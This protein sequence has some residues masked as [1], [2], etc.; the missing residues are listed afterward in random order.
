MPT[1]TTIVVEPIANELPPA[2]PHPY[3][4]FVNP[5]LGELLAKLRLDKRFVRGEGSHL[6]D[7]TGRQYLDCVAAYGALPFG[8]NPP[9]IWKS[10]HEVEAFREPSFVQPSLLEGAGDLAERLLAIAPGNFRYVTFTNS[11]AESIEAAIKML[12]PPPAAR[13]FFR[14]TTAFTAKRSARS[15]PREI[16]R[17]TRDSRRRWK[18]ST[19][20]PSAM[21]SAADRTAG[22][23]R[24]LRGVHGRTDSRRRGHRGAARRLP[25]RRRRDLHAKPACCW[26]STK[27]KP[28]WDDRARCSAARPKG[29]SPDVMTLAKALGGGLMP[30]GAV[31]EHR[32]RFFRPLLP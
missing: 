16:R 23:P 14:P 1:N 26:C 13:E 3:T 21:P 4:Q 9:E 5:H 8:F 22:S 7:E 25:G 10:L 27:S 24:L 6:Y 19:K 17:T 11:G 20:S 31:P 15:R 2:K 30:I 18:A 29:V 12:P 28:A 32:S